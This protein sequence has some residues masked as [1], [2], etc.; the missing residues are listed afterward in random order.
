MEI[1]TFQFFISY[2]LENL[3]SCMSFPLK[4]QKKILRYLLLFWIIYGNRWKGFPGI[5][6]QRNKNSASYS[7]RNWISKE[8]IEGPK[9]ISRSSWR[10]PQDIWEKWDS[11]NEGKDGGFCSPGLFDSERKGLIQRWIGLNGKFSSLFYEIDNQSRGI[12]KYYIFR[13]KSNHRKD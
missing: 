2:F 9:E 10:F 6:Q 5:L 7:N 8:M 11:K 4:K 13:K 3:L 1:L 12:D